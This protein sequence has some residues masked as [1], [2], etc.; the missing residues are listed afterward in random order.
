[1]LLPHSVSLISM[2]FQLKQLYLIEGYKPICINIDAS[3][4]VENGDQE[5]LWPVRIFV[6]G[7][8]TTCDETLGKINYLP[9]RNLHKLVIIGALN[10]V[11]C[12]F[13]FILHCFK[14][15]TFISI[16]KVHK[17]VCNNAIAILHLLLISIES[18]RLCY[19]ET[20]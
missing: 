6:K 15:L 13:G 8:L 17:Y 5:Y 4:S 20:P 1:M 9:I 3:Y 14:L 19:K 7:R 12:V 10:G 16:G 2:E 11:T 18:T